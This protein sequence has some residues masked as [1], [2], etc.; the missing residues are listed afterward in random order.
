MVV[1]EKMKTEI[2]AGAIAA[3]TVLYGNMPAF[4]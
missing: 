3:G 2:I 4:F 1:N